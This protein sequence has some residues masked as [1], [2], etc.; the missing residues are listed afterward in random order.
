M[1]RALHKILIEAQGGNGAARANRTSAPIAAFRVTPPV[2]ISPKPHL[3][4]RDRI[5]TSILRGPAVTRDN[6]LYF[7][8]GA[9][10][11]AVAVL[12]YELYQ[13]NKQPPE[14]VH[15]DIGP[16]GLSIEKK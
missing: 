9:L 12:G 11:I 10:V 7:I 2:R 14:G 16:K 6:V 8:I 3:D 1:T 15:I 4:R 5:A 13:A